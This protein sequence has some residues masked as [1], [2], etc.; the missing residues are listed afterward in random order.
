MH[1]IEVT[2]H[3]S[4]TDVTGQ[5][6]YAKPLEWMEWCR[7]DWFTTHQGPF[8]EYVAK[9][10]ITIFPARVTVDYKRPVAFGDRI[11]VE[12]T[13]RDAKRARFVLDYALKRGADTVIKGEI[14]M[15]CFD[16]RKEKLASIPDDLLAKIEAIAAGPAS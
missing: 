7:V 4:D 12:M 9:T 2:V 8:L 14:T 5:V 6:Y 3:L 11:T 16:T 15:V 13:A 10:G 1:S